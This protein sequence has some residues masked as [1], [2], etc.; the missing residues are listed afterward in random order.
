MLLLM[1]DSLVVGL[2]HSGCKIQVF[3]HNDTRKLERLLRDAVAYGQPRTHRPWKKIVIVVEGTFTHSAFVFIYLFFFF[4]FCGFAVQVLTV[5]G[6]YSM[7]GDVCDLPT[8]VQLKNKYKAYLYLDEAHSIGAMGKTGR[9][10]IEYFG[11]S[12]SC[13][14][15]MMGTFTKSF[16]SCG[17][18]IAASKDVIA[19]L[20]S[21]QAGLMHSTSM[22]SGCAQ[23][24]LSALRVMMN[25]QGDGDGIKRLQKLHENTNYF[26]TVRSV[27]RAI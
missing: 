4:L 25:E 7:E 20:R 6:I 9:G 12:P 18:Y 24:A 17:G 15:V 11:L 27:R 2:R 14:D 10:V 23:Q 19:Y 21:R 1:M 26:R 22:S 13:C 16:G 5:T 8:I 3:E